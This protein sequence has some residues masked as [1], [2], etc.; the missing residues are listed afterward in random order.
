M[1]LHCLSLAEKMG[2]DPADPPHTQWARKFKKIQAKKTRESIS[3]ILFFDQIPFFA[4]SKMVKN[5][6]SNWEKV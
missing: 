6:F 1:S 3:R 5:H 4:I 2:G